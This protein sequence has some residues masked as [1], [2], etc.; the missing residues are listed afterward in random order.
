MALLHPDLIQPAVTEEDNGW[1]PLPRPEPVRV[2]FLVSAH[3]GLSQRALVEL[4]KLGHDV[5]VAVV[6]SAAAIEA[7][8]DEH[9]PELIVCPFLT[10][11]IPESIWAEHRCLIVHPGPRGDRGPSSLDWAIELESERWGVT[12]L[13][14]N[15]QADAGAVL[16]TRDFELRDA[17]KSSLYRHEVRHAAVEALAEAMSRL[18]RPEGLYEFP[19]ERLAPTTGCARP[20]MR[21]D[22]RAID[23]TRDTTDMVLRKVRA[24]DGHPGV[25]DTI[26]GTEFHLFGAHRERALWGDRGQIIAQRHG[27]ICRATID[28]A[29]WITHLKRPDTA[30]ARH[31]KLPAVRALEL[32][33][34]QLEGV[35]EVE[36]APTAALQPA[37][38]WRELFYE[39]HDQVG[40]LHF[41][42]HNG[43]MSTDQCR[44]LRDAF[45]EARAHRSTKVIVL[46]GGED[47]F[48]NGIH[49]KLIEA[50]D[51]PGLESWRNLK[52]IDELVREIITTDSHLVISALSGDAAAGGVPLATAAD[53]VVARED[54]VL[55]PYY[56]HMG[57]LYGSEYWTYL[58]PR[59][60]G[61][62]VARRLTSPPFEAVG[63]REAVRLGLID[64]AYGESLAQFREQTRRIAA[65]IAVDPELPGELERKRGRRE[66]D[67]ASKPLA[68]YREQELDRSY[69]CFFG[70]DHSYH[71]ARRRFVYKLPPCQVPAGPEPDQQL[72]DPRSRA[73][74]RL[75]EA[76]RHYEHHV[77]GW[78]AMG[79]VAEAERA[80]ADILIR[81]QA[82]DSELHHRGVT[83]SP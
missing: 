16:A 80:R 5:T 82:V 44:R 78:Y 76:T 54:V 69:Q 64:A 37:S 9:R 81:R 38:T 20:L 30:D 74:D 52:S 10:T 49:L 41:D 42:F 11:M 83:G 73:E 1:T 7:A 31:F 40:Y 70:A 65:R 17:S 67:E 57:G 34:C 39:E 47:Y 12:V 72:R 6:E 77:L 18:A 33:D 2:L 24:G 14:A 63:A 66:R 28:G 27:A 56:R 8:V 59:R 22:A 32:A 61:A 53:L 35:P 25:L 3:N 43:A 62:D 46:M 13:E 50:A 15:G 21:Q 71:E 58:L 26:L 79:S 4:R 60:V 48:S 23:W 19:R 36:V 75:R 45:C 68:E 29:I 51:N 55:N